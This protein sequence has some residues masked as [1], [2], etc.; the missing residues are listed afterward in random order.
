MQKLTYQNSDDRSQNNGQPYQDRNWK[1]AL[2][3]GGGLL[4]CW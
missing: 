3:G 1:A 2:G 4:G